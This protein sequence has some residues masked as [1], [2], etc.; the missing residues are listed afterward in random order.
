MVESFNR[1]FSDSGVHVGL[2]HVEGSVTHD[3]KVL[4]PKT[5][6][7]RTVAFWKEGKGMSIHIREE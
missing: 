7:E 2:I 5:I 1:A 3:N 6:A 4:N